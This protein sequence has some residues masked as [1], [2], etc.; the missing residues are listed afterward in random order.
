MNRVLDELA[1]ALHDAQAMPWRPRRVSASVELRH[2][3]GLPITPS[4]WAELGR[5]FG[6]P[7]PPLERSPV[8]LWDFPHGWTTVWDLAGHVATHRP[9]WAPPVDRTVKEWREAQIFA[10][11]RAALVEALNVDEEDVVRPARLVDDLGA[12]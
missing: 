10:G 11:V 1:A 12:W 6:C 2:Q 4:R 5:S 9:Q 8:G 7:L 3:F